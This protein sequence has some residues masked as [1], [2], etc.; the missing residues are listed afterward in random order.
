M[1]IQN[2]IVANS[3][4]AGNCYGT[5]TSHGYNLSSDTSCTLRGFHGSGDRNNMAP[6]LGTLGNYGGLTQTIPLLSGSPAI[7]TGNPSGCTDGQGHLL[8]KDQRGML[9]PDPEDKDTIKPRCDRGAYESQ[10]D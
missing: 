5:L 6:K 1:T 8:T 4:T 7:D 2:S 10:T 9:R 3:S